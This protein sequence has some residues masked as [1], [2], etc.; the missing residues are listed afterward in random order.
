MS[1]QIRGLKELNAKIARIERGLEDLRGITEKATKYVRSQ[2][3]PYPAPPANSKYRRTGT[4]GR[5]IYDQVRPI[6]SGF[7]GVIGS[8]TIYGPWV[9]SEDKL[10]DGRGPQAAVHKGRWWT[11]QGVLRKAKDGIKQ[12]YS[13]GI[14]ALLR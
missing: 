13:A 4:L 2:I 10:N 5:E 7:I 12:I 6:M 1:V 11:L 3:P 14:K 8:P 9:I